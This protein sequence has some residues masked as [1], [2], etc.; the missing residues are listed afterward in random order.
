MEALGSLLPWSASSVRA[1]LLGAGAAGPRAS[2]RSPR[3]YGATDPSQDDPASRQWQY[4]P[5]LG[6]DAASTPRPEPGGWAVVGNW[7]AMFA[8]VR[9]GGGGWPSLWCN[10]ACHAV[11]QHSRQPTL[12]RSGLC[13]AQR[14]WLT[15]PD[16]TVQTG[17]SLL[18]TS[19]ASW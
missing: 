11:L 8:G 17:T 7:G 2:H 15:A 13:K 1:A 16:G 19:P 9:V 12:A 14:H 18:R 3:D 5:L 10:R 6:G 4:Q